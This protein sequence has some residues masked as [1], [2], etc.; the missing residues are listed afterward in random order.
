MAL[1]LYLVF[2]AGAC[3]YALVDWRRGWL[4]VIVCGVIQ[5]P[6]RKLTGGSPVYVSFLVV[7][8]YAV[9]LFSARN[10]MR[11]YAIEFTRRFQSISTGLV[12]FV[13][14]LVVAGLNG[15]VTYGFDKWEAPTVSFVT[16]IIPVIA[17]LLGYTWLQREEMMLRFFHIYALLTSV[18]LIGTVLEYMRV[19]SRLLGLVSFQGDYIRHLPGIQIRMLSGIYRSPDVMAWHAGMLTA[20]GVALALRAGFRRQMLLW[21]GVAAWGFINCMIAGRRKAIYFVLVFCIAFLWRYLRRVQM[22]QIVA[23]IGLLLLVFLVIRHLAADEGTSVYTRGATATQTE[24]TQRFEG[25]M[26]QT[27]RQV[28]LMGAGLGTAT[29]GVHH[30]LGS[31]SIGWQEGGLGKV[32]M[33]VG[34]PGVLALLLLI[35]LVGRMLMTLTRIHDVPGSSQF[36]RVMLFALVLANIA[37]FIGSAQAYTDA[38][39]ALTAGFLVGGLFASAALDERLPAQAAQT[40]TPLRPLPASAL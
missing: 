20:I 12:I 18:A 26:M 23:S 35:I 24:L 28:G 14:L 34:L 1:L 32:A 3:A 22:A 11:A 38:V 39:L 9:I 40:V 31:S 21:S 25:G 7:G 8:L 2:L 16:Y 4:L 17:A 30:L 36:M 37:G 13:G 5:D 6:V 33:E 15:V 19:N 27:F 10:E 29:Q